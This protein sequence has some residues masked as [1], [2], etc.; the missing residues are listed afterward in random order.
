MAG[1]AAN[2]DLSRPDCDRLDDQNIYFNANCMILESREVLIWPNA[3]VLRIVLGFP[4]RK[5]FVTLYASARN[6]ALCAG[7]PVDQPLGISAFTNASIAQASLLSTAMSLPATF[8]PCSI[9]LSLA[10]F[11]NLTWVDVAAIHLPVPNSSQ[12]RPCPSTPRKRASAR[13]Q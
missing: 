8:T 2:R 11:P 6:S 4:G 5:L 10:T 1:R 13:R 9:R 12:P 7:S 3:G